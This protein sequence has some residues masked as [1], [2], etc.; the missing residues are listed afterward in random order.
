MMGV[1]R[2]EKRGQGHWARS[3]PDERLLWGDGRWGRGGVKKGGGG[4][5]L[6]HGQMKDC[7]DDGK[8][9]RKGGRGTGLDRLKTQ[10]CGGL[11]SGV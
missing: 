9:E 3:W 1:G 7:W 8:G 6:D 4:T 11:R 2:G 10:G 5:G